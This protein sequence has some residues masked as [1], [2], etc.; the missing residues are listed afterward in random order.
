MEAKPF[1]V[2]INALDIFG[3]PTA[4]IQILDPQAE[5]PAA[6][7]GMGMA[8]RRRI[9]MAEM[10]PTRRRGCETCDLQD[11]LHDKGDGSDS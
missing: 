11:S 10:E 6:G 9:G 1:Q 3:P 5:L 8:K 7:T 2:F 4:G